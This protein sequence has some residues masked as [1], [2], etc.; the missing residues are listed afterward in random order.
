MRCSVGVSELHN[1]LNMVH[2]IWIQGGIATGPVSIMQKTVCKGFDVMPSMHCVCRGPAM[3]NHTASQPACTGSVYCE[4]SCRNRPAAA[5][6]PTQ[7]CCSTACL[8]RHKTRQAIAITLGLYAVTPPIAPTLHSLCGVARRCEA[9]A[10][11][12]CYSVPT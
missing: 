9:D 8:A 1:S 5:C 12:I 2:G 6:K 3:L 11:S 10:S 4:T 7:Y